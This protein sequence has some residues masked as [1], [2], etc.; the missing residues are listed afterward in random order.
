MAKRVNEVSARDGNVWADDCFELFIRPDLRQDTYY[1]LAGNSSG[2]LYDSKHQQPGT[3]DDIWDCRWN[4]RIGKDEHGW[5]ALVTIPFSDLGCSSPEDAIWGF[6][7]GGKSAA[8]KS[9][10]TSQRFGKLYFSHE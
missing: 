7:A 5:T 10:L 6:A 2:A 4:S 8:G 9:V 1:H 3:R